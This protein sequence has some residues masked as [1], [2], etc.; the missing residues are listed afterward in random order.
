VG[1][2]DSQ[3]ATA[4]PGPSRLIVLWAFDKGEDG[5][6]VPA[7]DAREM[8]DERRAILAAKGLAH[9][10]AGVIAWVREANLG[11]GEYGP[12]EVLYQHGTIPDL[13]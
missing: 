7:W 13:D 3:L 4:K 11:E 2:S 12:S 1:T 5:E 10:H 8:P 9:R 6:L